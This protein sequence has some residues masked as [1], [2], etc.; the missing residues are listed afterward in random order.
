LDNDAHG[1]KIQG[2]GYLKFLPKLLGSRLSGKIAWGDPLI[3]DFI[4]F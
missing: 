3:S 1:L 2:T 4:A